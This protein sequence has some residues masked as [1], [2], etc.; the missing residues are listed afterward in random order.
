MDL[1]KYSYHEALDRAHVVN[2]H[3][4]EYVET[5]VVVQSNPELKEEAEK[6]TSALY[7]FCCLCAEYSDKNNCENNCN[8]NEENEENRG[9]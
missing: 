8:D 2:D 6:L 7:N 5:H 3:F 1:D 9:K 4:Y